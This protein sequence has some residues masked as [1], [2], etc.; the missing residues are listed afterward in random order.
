MV[1]HYS[2]KKNLNRQPAAAQCHTAVKEIFTRRYSLKEPQISPVY[3]HS[4]TVY[5]HSPT[6]S[7]GTGRI[8]NKM[9]TAKPF[10][11]PTHSV[12]RK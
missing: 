3:L 1:Y 4:S 11:S 7:D 12:Q 2:V 8:Q 6:N 5:R 10:T 9:Y